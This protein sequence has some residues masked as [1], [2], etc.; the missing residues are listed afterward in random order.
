M[1]RDSEAKFRAANLALAKKHYPSAV[2]FRHEDSF[3]A[4][5]P[6]TSIALNGITSWWEFKYAEPTVHWR[7]AQGA[8]MRRLYSTGIPA[9]YL[10]FRED[11][12]G[13]HTLIVPATAGYKNFQDS[14]YVVDFNYNFLIQWIKRVHIGGT[15]NDHV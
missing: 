8:E 4:G 3:R 7:G 12:N 11:S 2:I 1:S 15:Q 13:R 14:H 5:V 9:H 6:D 10:I